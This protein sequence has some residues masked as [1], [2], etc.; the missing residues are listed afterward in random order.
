MGMDFVL[1]F[2]TI[3]PIEAKWQHLEVSSQ[4][5]FEPGPAPHK[6]EPA[7]APNYKPHED[8]ASGADLGRYTADIRIL[9]QKKDPRQWGRPPTVPAIVSGSRHRFRMRGA[10]SVIFRSISS[11]FHT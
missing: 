4:N 1:K 7:A 11:V 8:M 3:D 6:R 2:A 10:S 5:I 9:S